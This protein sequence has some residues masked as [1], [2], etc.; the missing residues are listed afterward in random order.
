MSDERKAASA[1]PAHHSDDESNSP[2]SAHKKPAGLP[3]ISIPTNFVKIAIDTIATQLNS[4]DL[5]LIDV[6][7]ADYEGGHIPGSINVPFESFDSKVDELVEK[8]GKAKSV[9]FYCMYGQ[10]RSPSCALTFIKRKKQ[11]LPDSL[12]NTFVLSG[13]FQEYLTEAKD[14][15]ST[16]VEGYDEKLFSHPEFLHIRDAD[17]KTF[18]PPKNTK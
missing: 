15:I 12:A 10:L 7:D 3:N 14:K 6:R 11:V 13:G 16:L 9:V 18:R 2:K 5:V 8:Y 4:P 17:V 1:S